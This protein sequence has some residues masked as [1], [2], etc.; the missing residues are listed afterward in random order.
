M[1]RCM[2]ACRPA[3]GDVQEVGAAAGYSV[4]GLPAGHG[5]R[6]H[7]RVVLQ[8][9][10]PAPCRDGPQARLTLF[11]PFRSPAMCIPSLHACSEECTCHN[12]QCRSCWRLISASIC[13][14]LM[15]RAIC[16]CCCQEVHHPEDTQAWAARCASRARGMLCMC[17]LKCTCLEFCFPGLAASSIGCQ[18]CLG[19]MLRDETT[20][21][22]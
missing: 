9:S 15:L 1:S 17:P 7:A 4:H 13:F 18:N 10:T 21:W 2:H 19:L 22:A 6:R 8:R 12:L 5:L 16:L 3:K 11:V 20:I 14:E